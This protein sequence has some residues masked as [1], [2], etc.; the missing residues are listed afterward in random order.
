MCAQDAAPTN[1]RI[2]DSHAWSHGLNNRLGGALEACDRFVRMRCDAG[3]SD[4]VTLINFDC[5]AKTVLQKAPISPELIMNMLA[6]HRFTSGGTV[7]SNAFQHA[8]SAL[9]RDDEGL[10]VLIMF[11]TDGGDGGCSYTLSTAIQTLAQNPDLSMKSMGFGSGADEANL[12]R[13]AGMF[14]ERGE[15][16]SAVNQVELV[17]SFEA[18]AA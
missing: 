14:G 15:Y 2:R 3:A 4:V 16:V 1:P 7:F 10:P 11:L 9:R 17:S 8:V 6:Y 13:I 18:A 5:N 12:R